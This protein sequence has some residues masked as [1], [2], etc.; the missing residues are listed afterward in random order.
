VEGWQNALQ[1]LAGATERICFLRERPRS[2]KT[3]R[4]SCSSEDSRTAF[5]TDVLEWFLN[6]S[7]LLECAAGAGL[8]LVREF[9]MQDQTPAAAAPEQARYR[10]F[11]FEPA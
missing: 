6:R 8:K 7:E 1:R 11:L 9:V 4:S 2:R 3:N 5:G 10:G